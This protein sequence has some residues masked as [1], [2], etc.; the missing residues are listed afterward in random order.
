MGWS[1][2]YL[3]HNWHWCTRQSWGVKFLTPLD[4]KNTFALL[5]TTRRSSLFAGK[6]GTLLK[7]SIQLTRDMLSVSITI[8]SSRCADMMASE[9]FMIQRRCSLRRRV[10]RWHLISKAQSPATD[11]ETRVMD[12]MLRMKFSLTLSSMSGLKLMKNDNPF[13]NS[14]G[15]ARSLKW[16]QLGW[17][18]L[19]SAKSNKLCLILTSTSRRKA[20]S[21]STWT[22]KAMSTQPR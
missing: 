6:L 3:G 2:T 7:L 21:W 20:R 12:C 8:S 1:T 14:R 10:K 13:I 5:L 16:L 4:V 17:R 18:V 19:I 11:L 15:K 22:S 9:S